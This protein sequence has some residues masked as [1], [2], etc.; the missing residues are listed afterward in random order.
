M[1]NRFKHV[2]NRVIFRHSPQLSGGAILVAA[3]ALY[4]VSGATVKAASQIEVDTDLSG[5][6]SL[7]DH[8]GK[9]VSDSDFRG[10]FMLIFFGYTY[11]P[12]VCPMDLQIMARAIDMLGSDGDRVQP[13]F[14]TV[15]PQRDTREVV[16]TYVNHFHRR[17]IGLTGSGKQIA[18]AARNYGVISIKI[19]DE[20]DPENY[21]VNHSALTYLLG[22]DG[23]FVAA[24]EHGMDPKALAEGILAHLDGQM[25]KSQESD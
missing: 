4:L 8:S 12:D 19:I 24:F 18:R 14:I 21:S 23:R 10:R 13:I 2:L 20:S 3:M 16:G 9:R 25:E 17:F 11:C 1:A 22:V 5:P 6:F 15:D 7:V